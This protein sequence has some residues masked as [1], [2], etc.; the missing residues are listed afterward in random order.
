MAMISAIYDIIVSIY[1]FVKYIH[2]KMYVSYM[3]INDN[4]TPKYKLHVL[5]RAIR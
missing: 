4:W 1:R 5:L 3:Y 2:D